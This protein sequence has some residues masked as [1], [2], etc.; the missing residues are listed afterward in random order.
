MRQSHLQ[1]YSH[2]QIQILQR[3]LRRAV[4]TNRVGLPLWSRRLRWER[5]GFVGFVGSERRISW[6]PGSEKSRSG[7]SGGRRPVVSDPSQ[8]RRRTGRAATCTLPHLRK[9]CCAGD[10]RGVTEELSNANFAR[11]RVLNEPC[12][13]PRQPASIHYSPGRAVLWPWRHGPAYPTH[14]PAGRR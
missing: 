2:R 6:A 4:G 9:R 14:W 3:S 11:Q 10:T 13:T 12:L 8:R 5:D 1:L 7:A